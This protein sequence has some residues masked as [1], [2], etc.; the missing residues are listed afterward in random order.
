[1]VDQRERNSDAGLTASAQDD[2]IEDTG[3]GES[4]VRVDEQG[5][6]NRPGDKARS[7][8][9]GTVSVDQD[10]ETDDDDEDE[11]D[12]DALEDVEK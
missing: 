3:T 9:A 2:L 7:G 5:I 4:G 6:S 12:D 1:M 10:A 8:D 11:P